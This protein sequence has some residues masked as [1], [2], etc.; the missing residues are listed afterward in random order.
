VLDAAGVPLGRAELEAVFERSWQRFVRAWHENRQFTA[1]HAVEDVLAETGA[2]VTPEL[3]AELVDA[4][5]HAGRGAEVRLTPNVAAC[6]ARLDEAGV[7]LGIICD[8]G[9]TPSPVLRSYLERHGVLHHFDHWSFSDEVGVYKPDGRIF[10][11]ALEGLGGVDPARAVH[12]GDLRRT[13][14]AGARAFGMTSV[15]YAGVADDSGFSAGDAAFEDADHVVA[16]HAELPALL[17]LDAPG[18]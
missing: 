9:L 2:Q 7:R 11:H 8:V 14:V 1:E 10:A 18:A 12:V 13:D 15:R 17:G 5:L 3:E 6:L 16:D 4:V